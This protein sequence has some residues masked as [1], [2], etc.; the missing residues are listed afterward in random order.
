MS[1]G[2]HSGWKCVLHDSSKGRK[3]QPPIYRGVYGVLHLDFAVSSFDF[4]L[5][6]VKGLWQ[7]LWQQVPQVNVLAILNCFD[8]VWWYWQKCG[9]VKRLH[10]LVRSPQKWTGYAYQLRSTLLNSI[11]KLPTFVKSHACHMDQWSHLPPSCG[12]YS[13][14]IG[15]KFT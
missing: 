13:P 7:R 1:W 3:G 9:I 15:G 12:L 10:H 4:L 6:L 11:V 2:A 8:Q 5:G 14:H